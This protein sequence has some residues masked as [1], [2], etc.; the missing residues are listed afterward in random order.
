MKP[1]EK[2]ERWANMWYE[3]AW[4]DPRSSNFIEM[5]ELRGIVKELRD[6]DL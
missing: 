3:R 6:R 4:N 1:S 5:I 2:L